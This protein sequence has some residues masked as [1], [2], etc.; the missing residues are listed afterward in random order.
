M[1]TFKA[2]LENKNFKISESIESYQS[3]L[4][5]AD[6]NKEL[7]Y[8]SLT[9]LQKSLSAH[10]LEIENTTWQNLFKTFTNYIADPAMHE[11]ARNIGNLLSSAATTGDMD[12]LKSVSN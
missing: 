10:S 8:K 7:D 11:D 4:K 5:D 3:I 2:W 9:K 12:I 6:I 1:K